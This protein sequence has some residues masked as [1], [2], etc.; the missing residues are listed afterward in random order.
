MTS[1]QRID[2]DDPE[3]DMN[4]GQCLLYQGEPFSGE[5]VEY[6]SGK[7]VSLDVYIE[8]VQSG[9]SREWY[10]DGTLRSAGM[11]K[12]GL[13]CGE[14]KEW[15]P[16]GTLAARKV[17]SDDGLTLLEDFSWDEEGQ[18]TRSWQLGEN[19]QGTLS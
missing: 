5:V 13:P 7:M 19:S 2:I 12:N 6:L 14:F 15:H 3:V 9:I 17:F 4:E 1:I 8:G 18:P 10:K 11:M 16:N